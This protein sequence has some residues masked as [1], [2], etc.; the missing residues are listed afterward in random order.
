MGL[1]IGGIVHNYLLWYVGCMKKSVEATPE[2][3]AAHLEKISDREAFYATHY[4]IDSYENGYFTDHRFIYVGDPNDMH[5]DGDYGETTCGYK[6]FVT[7]SELVGVERTLAQKSI[8]NAELFNIP[9]DVLSLN[10][11]DNYVNFANRSSNDTT[12]VNYGRVGFVEYQRRFLRSPTFTR[13]NTYFPLE[14]KIKRIDIA[15]K[16]LMH[17]L[18]SK[19]LS[20]LT[21]QSEEIKANIAQTQ[22]IL[23]KQQAKSIRRVWQEVTNRDLPHPPEETW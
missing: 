20:G 1:E 11:Y 3:T 5:N 16:G 18:Y 19:D 14:S 8:V 9:E 13:F 7:T 4:M 22:E 21:E 17:Y 15:V 2:F 6:N 12:T 23:D 10:N